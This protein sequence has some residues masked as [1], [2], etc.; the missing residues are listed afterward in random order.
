MLSIVGGT[1]TRGR[2]C[3]GIARR[4]FLRIGGLAGLGGVGGLSMPELLRAES[5]GGTLQRKSVIMIFLPG[6]P[7][8]QDMFDLKPDAPSEVRGEFRPIATNVPGIQMCELLPRLARITDKLAIVRS[9]VGATGDHYSF[10]CMTGRSHQRQPSGGWPELGSVV[11]KL[12]GA[13]TPA[14]PA[15]VGLSPRMQHTP[16]NSGKPGFLGPAYAPFQP[17]GDAKGDLVLSGLTLERLGDRGRLQAALDTFNRKVDATGLM[18]GMD[19]FQQQA[20]GV[21][22]SSALADALDVSKEP[23]AVRDRYGYGT[24]KHQGDGAPRLMQQLLA[25]RRLVEAGV[26]CVTLSFSFWD[27]HGGNFAN[28]RANLPDLDQGVSALIEDLHDR[29]MAD[30]VTVVVWGEFGR[31]PQINKDAGR[32]HWPNVSCALLAGGGLKT[33]QVIGATDRTAATVVE[34]PVRFEEIHATLY[35]R[36]GIDHLSTIRD[37]TGRPQYLTDHHAPLPE[38]V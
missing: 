12:E 31:T 25:A 37:L 14:T 35:N 15:Y 20:F 38:L 4:Q 18:D 27:Y 19:T 2:M 28:C 10:Q 22:T 26:R 6:G 29:G 9:I 1:P 34:R 23:P 8:H 36:L 16:Y 33:G 13:T 30:D 7:P 24:E 21:L 5:A 3:D 11:A 17:N 32:D